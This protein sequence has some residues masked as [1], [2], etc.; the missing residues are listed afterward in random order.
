MGA[1]EPADREFQDFLAK[2]SERRAKYLMTAQNTTPLS[3]GEA[4]KENGGDLKPEDLEHYGIYRRFQ[5]VT[6]RQIETQ[7]L[8]ANP[9]IRRHYQTIKG[10]ADHLAENVAEGKGLILLGACGTMKTTLSIAV[11]RVQIARGSSCY[12]IPMTTLMDEIFTRHAMNK[13][14][15]ARFEHRIRTTQLLVVDDLGSENTDV[16]WVR[17]K[18]DSILTERYNRMLPCII[19]SNLTFEELK[20]TYEMR[21]I[22]RLRHANMALM[23]TGESLRKSEQVFLP[24]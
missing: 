13:E 6:F 12:F 4:S 1:L 10:Y 21:L 15:C 8:P 11:M 2:V 16:G 22:D 3:L 7:G 5:K 19:T 18:V 17:S 20:G 23:F 14:D 9:V 24:Q